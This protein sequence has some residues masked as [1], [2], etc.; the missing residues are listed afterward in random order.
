MSPGAL[1]RSTGCEPWRAPFD[2]N[3]SFHE[4]VALQRQG[5]LR[6][7]EKVFTRVLKAAPDYFE[8]L[9]LLGTVKAQLGR[10]GEAHRLLSRRGQDQSARGRRLGQ[11]R[12]GAACAQAQRRS[13]RMPR[14]GARARSQRPH[15]SQSARQ[16]AAQSRPRRAGA[17]RI[18]GTF[19]RARRSMP[20]RGSIAASLMR[21]S[22]AISKPLPNS[23]RRSRRCPVIRACTIIAASRCYELGRYA[24]ALEAHDCAL[25]S[26][27]EHA[28][29]WL[30]RGARACRAQPARRGGEKLRQSAERAGKDHPD[31]QF[32]EALALLTLGDYRTRL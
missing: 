12:S 10:M 13:A 30:H 18:P 22:A 3:Q 2:I 5:K 31:I 27:P 16:R 21:R 1:P 7:A 24:A 17:R 28:G 26:A 25:A 14:Q 8:A 23:M 6:D 19:W 11:S 15:H 9:N 29:A 20:R 4:A 32:S